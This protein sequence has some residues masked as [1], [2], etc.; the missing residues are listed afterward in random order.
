M[1]YLKLSSYKRAKTKNLKFNFIKVNKYVRSIY[2]IKYLIEELSSYLNLSFFYHNPN[3]YP[4]PPN[5]SF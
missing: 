4:A 3:P 2:F 1:K 5:L